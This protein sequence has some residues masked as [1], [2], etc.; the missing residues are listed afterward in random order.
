MSS[1]SV[2]HVLGGLRFDLT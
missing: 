2:R 1:V